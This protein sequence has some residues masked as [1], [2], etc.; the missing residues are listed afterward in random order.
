MRERRE[1]SHWTPW[2]QRVEVGGSCCLRVKVEYRLLLRVASESRQN[3]PHG[4]LV[5]L[6]SQHHRVFGAVGP[7]PQRSE[8]TNAG[9]DDATH[10][11]R[12]FDERRLFA[13]VHVSDRFVEF[14]VLFR[15]RADKAV[16]NGRLGANTRRQREN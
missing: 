11:D 2:F 13:R 5:A 7:R 15:A 4:W 16:V 12:L 3:I 1:I 6:E 9:T 14:Q 8:S 10:I